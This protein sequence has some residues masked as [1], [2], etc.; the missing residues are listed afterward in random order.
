MTKSLEEQ[1]R[2]VKEKR[3]CYGCMKIGHNAK[4]CCHHH[5]CEI[6]KG[7]CPTCLHNE[8]YTKREKPV[9]Q[10]LFTSSNT[11]YTTALSLNAAREGHAANMSMIVPV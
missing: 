6:C 7:K 8:N 4:D 5:S 1:R 9:S 11:E 10:V 3:L 2:F